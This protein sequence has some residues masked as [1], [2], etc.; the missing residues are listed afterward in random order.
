TQ[1]KQILDWKNRNADL[2][3]I[4]SV[5]GWSYSRPFFEMISTPENR[6]KFI[7]SLEIWLK[8]PAFGF[9]DGVDFDFEFPGGAGHDKDV[10]DPSIDGANYNA[11]IID[12]TPDV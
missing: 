2:N 6:A 5:G 1:F 4:V 11:F 7:D 3:V 9:I 10:G 12:N 8:T